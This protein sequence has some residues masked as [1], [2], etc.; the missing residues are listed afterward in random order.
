[1]YTGEGG[2]SGD[3][4]ITKPANL[5]AFRE[6]VMEHTSHM[7]VHFVMGDGVSKLSIV[8]LF[9]L[10]GNIGGGRREYSRIAH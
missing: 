7:D 9:I 10:A 4:D 8:F 5:V 6:Y 3:G 1:M 2:V